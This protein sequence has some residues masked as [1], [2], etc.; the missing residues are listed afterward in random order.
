MMIR[1]LLLS[2]ACLALGGSAFA[3]N[4]NADPQSPDTY[5]VKLDTTAGPVVIEVKRELA[6]RGADRFYRLVKEGF[7]DDIRA[8]RVLDG[9]VAQFGMAGDPQTN[10]KWS[11]NRIPD[12]PVKISNKK[13]T[14]VFATSGKNSRTTQLF[15]NYADNRPLDGMGFAPFGTVVEGMENVTKFYSGYGEGAPNGNG[16]SQELIRSGGNAYLDQKFPKLTKIKTARVVSEN[17]K[18]VEQAG[19]KE[20]S[21]K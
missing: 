6:P 2:L 10:A 3:Q 20:P 16:P 1:P 21:A 8:F 9:F 19:D 12:D 18:P 17:G 11:E 4:E 13:G 14:I 7:Y 5:R 15:I